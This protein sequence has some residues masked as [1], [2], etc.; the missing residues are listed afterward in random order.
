MRLESRGNIIEN[1]PFV[2]DFASN[3]KPIEFITR[4][5][6]HFHLSQY[7]FVICGIKALRNT[8]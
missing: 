7:N 3:L 1:R 8:Q 5:V 2:Y 4:N 6:D